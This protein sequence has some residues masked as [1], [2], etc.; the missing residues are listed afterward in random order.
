LLILGEQVL[1][2][3]RLSAKRRAALMSML[4]F[5]VGQGLALPD[6]EQPPLGLVMQNCYQAATKGSGQ[7]IGNV[8]S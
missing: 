5:L 8:I 7:E 4:L 1:D 2:F 3:V 6:D